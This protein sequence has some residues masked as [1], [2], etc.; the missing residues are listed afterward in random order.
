MTS[1]TNADTQVPP[2]IDAQLPWQGRRRPILA[3]EWTCETMMEHFL[4]L[5]HDLDLNHSQ[6]HQAFDRLTDAKFVTQRVMMESQAEKVALA[7]AAADKAISKSEQATEKRFESVN[8]FRK[9]LSDQAANFISRREFEVLREA[10]AQ[11]TLEF[12]ARLDKAEG[13]S[14]GLDAAWVYLVGAFG[15]IAALVGVAIAIQHR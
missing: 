9:T 1:T 5:L 4:S 12:S 10:Q 6:R 11:R 2:M 8:E 13:R 15:I 7:L 3:T 14:S